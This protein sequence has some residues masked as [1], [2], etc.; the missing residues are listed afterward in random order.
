MRNPLPARAGQPDME[1]IETY[2]RENQER[3]VQSLC[4]YVRFPSVS[5]QP[6]HHSDVIACADWLVAHCKRIGLQT[7]LC[8][9]AGNPVV[10]ARTPGQKAGRPH[11]LVYGH[12]DVQPAE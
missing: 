11:Y 2:L 8:P 9:T 4:E 10:L 5:A 1:T 7:T 3:F 12:Y 6:Q